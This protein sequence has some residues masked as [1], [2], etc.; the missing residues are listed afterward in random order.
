[1]TPTATGESQPALT[2]PQLLAALERVLAP[3]QVRPGGPDDAVDGRQPAAVASPANTE[4]A[5]A[6]LRMAA[7]AGLH[8]LVRGTGSKLRWGNPPHQLDLVVDTARLDQVLEH[9]AGDLVIRVQAGVRL[10][11]VQERV[12]V[13]GQ[14]LALDPPADGSLG[15]IVAA[16]ASGPLRHRFRTA[17]DLL[18][19]STVVLAD[20]TVARS[21]GKVVKNVA[22][23]DLG[24]LFTGSFGTLG[25]LTELVFRLHPLPPAQRCLRLAVA[26]AAVAG[27]ASAALTGCQLVPSAVELRWD[28]TAGRGDLDVLFEGSAAS[29]DGQSR[30][31]R[32]LLAPFGPVS[33]LAWSPP[34]PAGSDDVLVKLT[35]PP[36]DLP[37]VLA[38]V[39][40]AVADRALSGELSG[41]A[42]VGVAYLRCRPDTDPDRLVAAV[43]DLRAALEPLHGQV[44]VL[45]SPPA[46]PALADRWG[47]VPALELMRRVK[48]RFDPDHRLAPGRF[49]GG[50]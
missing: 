38:A 2:G 49:V 24:K 15:G 34:A 27:A 13:A 11:A 46:A 1:M 48:D 16:A 45:Q 35:A 17:R 5:A 3:D 28:P 32:E 39:Q 26:D 29:A 8:L 31:A 4:Q 30:Q 20:G 6:L 42:G 19:G 43:D 44:V 14:R 25:L 9:V 37:R 41:P 18:I 7:E 21:G 47:P 36:A 40:R 23:Y 22:G 10:S 12:G 50:I 33:E